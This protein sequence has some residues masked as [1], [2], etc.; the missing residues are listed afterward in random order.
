MAHRAVMFIQ[1]KGLDHGLDN[2]GRNT[3]IKE[4]ATRLN[5]TKRETD[6]L[7]YVNGNLFALLLENVPD[8][9]QSDL[10]IKRVYD[11]ISLPFKIKGQDIKIEP[12]IFVSICTGACGAAKDPKK[13]NIK[14]CYE[15]V[16]T[17]K[18]DL[19]SEIAQ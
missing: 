1:L 9:T 14:L 4:G 10:I 18:T 16:R 15:C 13:A 7:A 8:K 11:A 5:Y 12:D 17:K 2:L 3:L 19:A 6:T